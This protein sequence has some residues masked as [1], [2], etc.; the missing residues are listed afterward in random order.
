MK[1]LLLSLLVVLGSGSVWAEDGLSLPPFTASYKV[2]FGPASGSLDLRLEPSGDRW[3]YT[4]VL[5]PKGVARLF[6]RGKIE[7]TSIIEVT[8]D[9]VR[10]LTYDY[11]DTVANP[12]RFANYAFDYDQGAVFG[13]YKDED[14]AK[15]LLPW[16]QDRLSLQLALMNAVGAG[17]EFPEFALF[18]RG[19]WRTLALSREGETQVKTP[20]GRFDVVRV[21]YATRKGT[22]KEK[23]WSLY[24]A[25]ALN[26][27][28]VVIEQ[29]EDGKIRVR[30][31]LRQF[32]LGN[33]ILT[34]PT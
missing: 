26:N 1:R 5:E 33:A 13:R 4:A 22:P 27:L 10:P 30:A 3:A 15:D 14:V 18:D 17:D 20:A 12:D 23:L 31:E 6:R 9:V 11:K 32:T 16:G 24:C 29:E 2:K 21:T 25:P 8:G 7:E 28:P 19:R 34:P